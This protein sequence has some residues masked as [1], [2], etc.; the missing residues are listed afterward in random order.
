ML[1]PEDSKRFESYFG[2]FGTPEWKMFIKEISKT[3]HDARFGM[4]DLNSEEDRLILKG[5]IQ[6]MEYIMHFE[7]MLVNDY[8]NRMEFD[9]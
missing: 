4:A 2:M 6:A 5:R 9:R 7:T 3:C 8:E 1:S